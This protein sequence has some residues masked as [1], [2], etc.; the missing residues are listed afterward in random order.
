MLSPMTQ[1]D[2]PKNRLTMRRKKG[3][4]AQQ[5]MARLALEPGLQAALSLQQYCGSKLPELTLDALIAEL[6]A[7]TEKMGEDDFSRPEAMLLAQAQTLDAI[8]NSLAR[9]AI[10]ADLLCHLESFLRL[11][12]KAQAQCRATLATLAAM[13]RPPN[14]A[15][16][17]AP[18][19]A[20][21][22]QANI[23][24]NIAYAPQ[25]VNNCG[26]MEPEEKPARPAGKNK[27]SKNKLLSG[28]G[29]GQKMDPGATDKTGRND[30]SMETVGKINRAKNV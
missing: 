14:S 10:N 20:Y 28:N 7:Q 16:N 30:P 5:A 1:S 8:F 19:I 23:A 6:E 3:E 11:G 27:K 13:K 2:D 24:P 22:N 21:V 29:H 9:R 25:Q 18:N 15:P 17:I 26:G 4:T 12:L